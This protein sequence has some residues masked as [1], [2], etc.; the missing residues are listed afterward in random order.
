MTNSQLDTPARSPLPN[1]RHLRTCLSP[2]VGTVRAEEP[3][4]GT[5][6]A[7]EPVSRISKIS[8]ARAVLERAW[9][10][11]ERAR[12]DREDCPHHLSRNLWILNRL[13]GSGGWTRSPAGEVVFEVRKL[14]RKLEQKGKD[15]IN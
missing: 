15:L 1:R 13:L 3:V 7:E 14:L 9:R 10:Q 11:A 8:R 5:V 6:R 2:V 12:F 4:V